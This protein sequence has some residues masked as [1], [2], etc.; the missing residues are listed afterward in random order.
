MFPDLGFAYRLCLGI[1][2]SVFAM[3]FYYR[4]KSLDLYFVQNEIKNPAWIFIIIYHHPFFR[5]VFFLLCSL[6]FLFFERLIDW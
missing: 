5:K 3:E 1:G 4:S 2:C 6:L